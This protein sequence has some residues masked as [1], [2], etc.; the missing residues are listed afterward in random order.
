MLGIP[1]AGCDRTWIT[2]LFAFNGIC[3]GANY[4]AIS[5]NLI[6]LAPN[7]AGI[8]YGVTNAMS[9]LSSILAPWAIGYITQNRTYL[10][11]LMKRRIKQDDCKESV[12]NNTNNTS[13]DKTF[14]KS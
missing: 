13:G 3:M 6:A 10:S 9:N 12:Y 8:T 11:L 2:L 5:T 7:Y 1:L 14:I 4:I